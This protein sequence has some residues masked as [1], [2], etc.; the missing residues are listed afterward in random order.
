MVQQKE[1][2]PEQPAAALQLR[3]YQQ[4]MANRIIAMLNK[5]PNA[6]IMAQAPTGSGKT[7]LAAW[8][9]SDAGPFAGR[10][11]CFIPHRQELVGQTAKRFQRYGLPATAGSASG[12]HRMKVS[13]RD[14]S[15]AQ[16]DGVTVI[17]VES[18]IRRAEAGSID[19]EGVLI[20]DEAHTT[21]GN[22]RR[23]QAFRRHTGP[24]LALTATPQR[25]SEHEDFEGLCR[26]FVPGVQVQDLIDAGHLASYVIRSSRQGARA[27]TAVRR[28][29]ETDA[30]WAARIY[31]DE[32]SAQLRGVL[33]ETAVQLW[34]IAETR[35]DDSKT[36]AFACSLA[37]ADRLRELLEQRGASAVI[38]RGDHKAAARQE[39]MAQFAQPNVDGGAEVLINVDMVREGFDCPEADILLGVRPTMSLA[40]W[41]QMCGRVLRPKPDG[42]QALILDLADNAIE[43]G[44]P[45][46][47]RQWTLRGA[48]ERE[49]G[50][51][52]PAMKC[53]GAV[54]MDDA[55]VYIKSRPIYENGGDEANTFTAGSKGAAGCDTVNP[56]GNYACSNCGAEFRKVCPAD[57]DGCGRERSVKNWL[58]TYRKFRPG[59]C[60][61]CG[62]KEEAFRQYL[63]EERGAE[64]T[65]LPAKS[66]NGMLLR[67]AGEPEVY[68]KDLDGKQRFSR[69]WV[70]RR[71]EG[72]GIAL[73]P[74]PVA[75]DPPAY[76]ALHHDLSM[77]QSRGKTSHQL[78]RVA[79]RALAEKYERF[80]DDAKSA[81]GV[82][83]GRCGIVLH[84][85]GFQYCRICETV[86]RSPESI[87]Q[88][89]LAIVAEVDLLSQE[90]LRAMRAELYNDAASIAAQAA[91]QCR[92]VAELAEQAGDVT[93]AQQ[94]VARAAKCE[95]LA[96][97]TKTS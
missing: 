24:L 13:W 29:S 9:L 63:T 58:G 7:E 64:L 49:L 21:G 71:R 28:G 92:R 38:L 73:L 19:P 1:L 82:P 61:V 52:P 3:D 23:Q 84:R 91:E 45:S 67:L 68:P 78:Q 6:R 62:E 94:A 17:G 31:A 51:D 44:L 86:P 54:R 90:Y 35:R 65:W 10:R 66:G 8:L 36:L 27:L 5:N 74:A 37:H 50:G 32:P 15:K 40:L 48:K 20:I 83:C 56:A 18:W 85:R 14:K 59:A 57:P 43:H 53:S 95:E 80:G 26:Q 22:E 11:A 60:D 87:R 46:D 93:A 47:R 70:G 55:G 88:E 30:A 4:D 76:H 72:A 69:I 2:M 41:L 42:R 77:V 89:Y 96:G 34:E 79:V 12:S 81:F 16:P 25:M 39:V 75:L 33:T 97:G